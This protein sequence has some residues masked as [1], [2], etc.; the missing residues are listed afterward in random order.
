MNEPLNDLFL[1]ACGVAGHWTLRISRAEHRDEERTFTAPYV[2]VGSREDSDLCLPS[3]QV[4]RKHAYFQA[5]PGGVYCVDLDSRGGLRFGDEVRPSG[6]LRTDRPV[7]LGPYTLTLLPPPQPGWL[8]APTWAPENPLVDHADD[9]APLVPVFAEVLVS[10]TVRVRWRMNRVMAVIGRAASCHVYI[11]DPSLSRF[12][13]SLV[14]TPIGLWVIDLLSREG[15]NLNGAPVRCERLR[16]G[17]ELQLGKYSLRIWFRP[18]GPTT[19]GPL[20]DDAD[21]GPAATSD[22]RVDGIPLLPAPTGPEVEPATAVVESHSR[23]TMLA[24]PA[25]RLGPD[26]AAMLAMVG[27]FNRMQQE[28]FDHFQERLLMATRLFASLH[29]EQTDLVRE[30][31]ERISNIAG[32]L[33]TLQDDLARRVAALDPA[34]DEKTA[35]PAAPPATSRPTPPQTKPTSPPPPP[36]GQPEEDV[37]AWLNQRISALQEEQESR[38]HKLL[39]R[40]LGG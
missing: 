32:E 6:W 13:C 9:S 2:L 23:P 7:Q 5:L 25:D 10:G 38:W 15:T 27:Q 19:G 36:P 11:G 12:H 8:A 30:E 39:G 35:A 3:S 40:I 1:A 21:R 14:R 31:L 22:A 4:S 17:D 28:M 16:D 33:R 20:A 26:G 18:K 34:P 24:G 37:H 29:K